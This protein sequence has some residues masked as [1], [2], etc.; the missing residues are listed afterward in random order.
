MMT[1]DYNRVIAAN[2]EDSCSQLRLGHASQ[3]W[4]VIAVIQQASVLM[5]HRS[6]PAKPGIWLAVCPH[7]RAGAV[8]EGPLRQVVPAI[9]APPSE[10]RLLW[11]CWPVWSLYMTA[12]L[13]PA[14]KLSPG[15]STDNPFHLSIEPRLWASTT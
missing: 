10:A 12:K 3:Q 4:E 8:R 14:T 5:G 6:S 9:A 15:P 1:A 13:Q 7:A 2:L 11:I